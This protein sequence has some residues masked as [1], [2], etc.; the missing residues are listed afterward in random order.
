MYK[1]QSKS[2]VYDGEVFHIE[3]DSEVDPNPFTEDFSKA[4]D[5]GL[6]KIQKA[7][8][9]EVPTTEIDPRTD[10]VYEYYDKETGSYLNDIYAKNVGTYI[11]KASYKG[12]TDKYHSC[13]PFDIAEVEITP[14]ELKIDASK[15][16]GNV[17]AGTYASIVNNTINYSEL[18]IDGY[19]P[20]DKYASVSYTHHRAH[21]TGGIN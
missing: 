15:V 6:I 13:A 3:G 21:E 4:L 17:E 2:K 8:G 7:D 11:L 1:R 5:A 19:A 18:L 14:R 16:L 10:L 20:K 12:D 9:T